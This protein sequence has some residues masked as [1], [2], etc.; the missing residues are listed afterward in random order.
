MSLQLL[1]EGRNKSAQEVETEGGFLKEYFLGES[2][3]MTPTTKSG[4]KKG[5]NGPLR[6]QFPK[7][8]GMGTMLSF[9]E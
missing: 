7:A 1:T 9:E 2:S 3:V 5:F 6:E 8:E 4:L